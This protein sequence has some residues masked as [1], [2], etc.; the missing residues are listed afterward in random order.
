MKRFSRNSSKHFN[1]SSLQWTSL[2]GLDRQIRGLVIA[3]AVLVVVATG[4]C[5]ALDTDTLG[6][7]G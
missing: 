5:V 7:T 4:C 2:W 6:N 3:G 1:L